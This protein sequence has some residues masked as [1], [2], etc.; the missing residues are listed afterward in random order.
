MLHQAPVQVVLTV[1][2]HVVPANRVNVRQEG[3]V[4]LLPVDMINSYEGA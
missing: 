4:N 2:H 3:F 1:E